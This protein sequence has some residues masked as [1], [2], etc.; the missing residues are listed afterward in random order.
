MT[1]PGTWR[2]FALLPST[3]SAAWPWLLPTWRR[4]LEPLLSHLSSRP[5]R[6][7]WGAHGW[8]YCVLLPRQP[9]GSSMRPTCSSMSQT[10]HNRTRA[11]QGKRTSGI[12]KRE[13]RNR[14]TWSR[15]LRSPTFCG[16]RAGVQPVEA[17][18]P[19]GPKN[20]GS[21]RGSR[22]W[23]RGGPAPSLVR[24]REV[25]PPPPFCPGPQLIRR[26][27]PHRGR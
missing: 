20:Q 6:V 22:C 17:K 21:G 24:R 1:P 16:L 11:L 18:K 9:Q 5:G 10:D 25:S 15:R 27:P 12:R 23:S 4:P 19:G 14:R 7:G 13:T 2:L 3:C 26:G 8:C